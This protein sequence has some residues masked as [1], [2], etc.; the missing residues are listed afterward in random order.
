MRMDEHMRKIVDYIK[1]DMPKN[2][3]QMKMLENVVPVS[4]TRHT[5]PLEGRE[6]GSVYYEADVSDAPLI[7]GFHGDGF[8]F[9]GASLD[10]A[11][12]RVVAK[13]TGCQCGICRI[14]YDT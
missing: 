4:G 8:L 14:S 9:G 12:W 13:K 6:L 2:V 5:I 10:D 7:L 11:M 1:A 3:P